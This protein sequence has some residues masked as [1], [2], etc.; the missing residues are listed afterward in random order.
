MKSI[1]TLLFVACSILAMNACAQ[2]VV[3]VNKSG[4]EII[5]NSTKSKFSYA[6]FRKPIATDKKQN[7]F[8]L[9][10][11]EGEKVGIWRLAKSNNPQVV[12]FGFEHMYDI[13]PIRE[14]VQDLR[15]ILYK[16]FYFRDVIHYS[17]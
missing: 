5:F 9:D 7:T 3:F 11:N 1:K 4:E 14:D 8:T 17:K 16:D 10:L 12:G 6:S 2:K 13:T 15:I